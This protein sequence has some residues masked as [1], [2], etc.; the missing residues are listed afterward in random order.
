MNIKFKKILKAVAIT[1]CA[2]PILYSGAAFAVTDGTLVVDGTSE[3]AR[4]YDDTDTSGTLIVSL[5]PGVQMIYYGAAS[6]YAIVGMNLNVNYE[7]R[8]EYAV[9]SD[10]EGYY[11]RGTTLTD[12]TSNLAA[13]TLTAP[14]SEGLTV[15]SGTGEWAEQ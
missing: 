10:Y 11:M 9:A 15:G 5:S 4:T 13:D 3:T 14:N 6:T 2:L 8:N 7:V 12:N 1:A